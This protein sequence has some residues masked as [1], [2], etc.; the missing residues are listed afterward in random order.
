MTDA[1]ILA[2]VEAEHRRAQGAGDGARAAAWW[3]IY[4]WLSG[5]MIRGEVDFGSWRQLTDATYRRFNTLREKAYQGESPPDPERQAAHRHHARALYAVRFSLD[6]QIAMNAACAS[7]AARMPP[8]TQSTKH[9][10]PSPMTPP[11][12]RAAA[13][14][15]GSLI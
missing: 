14:Q 11:L 9:E 3:D 8:A 10:V 15:Q 6:R 5:G 13:A 1:D 2:A 7:I 4:G 12:R